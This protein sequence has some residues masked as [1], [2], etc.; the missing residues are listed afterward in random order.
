MSSHG[1][2]GTPDAT[3]RFRIALRALA[4][5]GLI[6]VAVWAYRSLDAPTLQKATTDGAYQLFLVL[7]FVLL[8]FAFAAACEI[9]FA[10]VD[11][12]LDWIHPG[13]P[14]PWFRWPHAASFATMAAIAVGVA[15]AIDS[16]AA[17]WAVDSF[18]AAARKTLGDGSGGGFVSS[19]AG[20]LGTQLDALLKPYFGAFAPP[21]A[22]APSWP[23]RW[24][25]PMAIAAG[26][27][28]WLFRRKAAADRIRSLDA[29]IGAAVPRGSSDGPRAAPRKRIVVFCDGTSNSANQKDG[30]VVAPTNVNRLYTLVKRVDAVGLPQVAVYD[31]GVGT[32]TSRQAV[33]ASQLK[34]LA[35]LIGAKKV[36]RQSQRFSKLRAVWELATG[37]GILENVEQGYR[38]IVR[39]Y[40]PGDEIWLFGFSRGAYTV[41]CIAGVISRC[42][43]LTGDNIRFVPDVM[44]LY[45]RRPAG[46]EQELVRTT[47]VHRDVRIRFVGL[48]DT[49]ASLGLPLWGWWFRVG[50]LWRNQALN[51]NPAAICENVYQA[52]SIDE[53]RSQFMPTLA[54]PS[55][56]TSTQVIR[57]V[58]FRG[59]HA[60]VGGGYAEHELADL[61]LAWMAR[62][63]GDCGLALDAT[64]L[65]T[66]DPHRHPFAPIRTAVM[67][68]PHWAIF[69][70]W[71]RWHPAEPPGTAP[72]H[73]VH[74][75]Y[76]ALDESVWTRAQAAAPVAGQGAPELVL[77]ERAAADGL[78][79]LEPGQSAIATI[80][81]ARV[82]NRTGVV[83]QPG[84]LYEITQ[85][86][87][88]WRDREQSD[89]DAAGDRLAGIDLVRRL[90][91]W[92][93]RRPDASYVELV[94]HVA[95]P[96]A[97]P[98]FEFG[99][100]KLLRYFAIND[101]WPL[102][103]SLLRIGKGL[104]EGRRVYVHS[105]APAGVF[106]AFANDLWRYY[107]NN[108]GSVRI[109]IRR[110]PP[111][112]APATGALRYEIS[113]RGEV[114][115][116]DAVR[117]RGSMLQ[118]PVDM[119]LAKAAPWLE[120][121][122]GI[123]AKHLGRRVQLSLR[124]RPP[125]TAAA[126]A[127][128]EETWRRHET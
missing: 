122:A 78:L 9:L 48:W 66:I 79:F 49:V 30:E 59:G 80:A 106:Y 126:E 103:A 8:L 73:P 62:H 84:V 88:R 25:Q 58:W 40:E 50:A 109:A 112:E 113:R 7:T 120:P 55:T 96:R 31:P 19:I 27:L 94:G 46:R 68:N 116:A 75:R 16:A 99:F 20:W 102:R 13:W 17:I 2:D 14:G 125:R 83:L 124:L 87:G 33:R 89:C 71:P 41:R 63:A 76:G 6:A 28:A 115:E 43:L 5:I 57:Q 4:T 3:E 118:A 64:K 54:E 101:P 117:R 12:V 47:H 45:R 119:V 93:R 98:A 74:R 86:E 65:P 82:W 92:A 1:S 85:R 15:L 81:A 111:H 110:L 34:A 97:W 18:K 105:Q 72:D 90:F 107:A 22:S 39:L 26:L 37:A 44:L 24:A 108:S 35:E 32:E 61:A 70:T 10:S 56:S 60:E 67:R 42:G 91:A 69:G 53:T 29:S 77:D 23:T 114:L 36:A 127:E 95:H 100:F 123:L 51:N 11:A 104:G 128:A 38:E 121:L 21:P 52:L